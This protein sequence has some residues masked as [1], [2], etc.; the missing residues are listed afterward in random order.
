M[1]NMLIF[2]FDCLGSDVLNEK[3]LCSTINIRDNFSFFIKIVANFV[4]SER[5]HFCLVYVVFFLIIQN[6]LL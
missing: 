3:K 2:K 1:L 5:K 6:Y 4:C